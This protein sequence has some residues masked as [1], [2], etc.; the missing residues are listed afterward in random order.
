M[1]PIVLKIIIIIIIL[2]VIISCGG[3]WG[4]FQTPVCKEPAF[5]ITFTIKRKEIRQHVNTMVAQQANSM[6]CHSPGH[7]CPVPLTSHVFECTSGV[8]QHDDS[9]EWQIQELE[10]HAHSSRWPLKSMVN[11]IH[12]PW[13]SKFLPAYLH[14]HPE[15]NALLFQTTF[16]DWWRVYL[17]LP[18]ESHS[19]QPMK[20]NKLTIYKP[21]GYLLVGKKIK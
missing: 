12:R 2:I 9:Q 4:K 11:G 10:K 13:N 6:G 19:R 14:R 3:R 17:V 5:T 15:G 18:N 20:V 1:L 21:T 16:P 7:L 8:Q